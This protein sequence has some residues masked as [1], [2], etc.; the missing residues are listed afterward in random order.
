MALEATFWILAVIGV[1]AALAV[2]LLGNV[3][4]AALSLIVCFLAVAGIYVTLSAGFLAAVQVLIYVGAIAILIILAI[5][6]TREVQRGS[7]F[8]RLRAP[9]LVV[10]I[11]TLG[12]ISY[13]V[14]ATPW[15]VSAVPPLEPTTPAIASRLFGAGG[16]I[17]PVEIVAVLVL[18]AILGAII[19]VREK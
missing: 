5:M 6:L 2:V 10:A 1:G 8:G 19:L 9:A 15:Q 14:V 13:A 16:F 4:R 3:F 17:L 7:P 11:L 18:A 12:V